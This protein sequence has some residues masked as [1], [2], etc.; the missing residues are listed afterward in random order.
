MKILHI[1]TDSNIGGA[2]HYL[3]SLLK[4][5]DRDNFHID[6]VLPEGSRLRPSVENTAVSVTE[7]P[8]IKDRSF[9]LK[10]IVAI[11]RLLR[12]KK[13]DIVH[14]HASF[15]GR[16]AAKML[17]LPVIYTRHYCVSKHRLNF[18]NNL[19]SDRV[20]ATAQEVAEGL[21]AAGTKPERITIILNGSPPLRWLSEEEKAAVRARYGI[22]G[23]AFVVSQVARLDPVKGHDHS[24]DAAKILAKDPQI[25]VLLAGDGILEE[26]LRSRIKNENINNV[27]MTGFVAAVEEIHNITD[28]QISASYTETSCLALIEGMSLGI[29]SVA[30][31][32]GGNPL[33]ITH[34]ER[35]L[36]VPA[37]DAAAL[38]EAVLTIKN[39]PALYRRFSE[40]ALEGY[41]K[42][43]RAEIMARQIEALYREVASGR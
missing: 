11:Y 9:S 24:L 10:A 2:G 19:F 40:G 21:I 39:D 5:Y 38:A 22:S 25:V 8:Y 33:V 32:G 12:E 28:L 16:I 1:L 34:G 23:D 27:I 20:V 37:G 17:G 43:F 36:V 4:S 6:V 26:H 41:N 29:P 42:H 35:G 14:T 30:S 7:L 3:L 15:S 31:D 13:P 18:V